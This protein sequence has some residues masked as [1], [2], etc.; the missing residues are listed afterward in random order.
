MAPRNISPAF[1]IVD[2]VCD[3]QKQA[4]YIFIRINCSFKNKK[5]QEEKNKGKRNMLLKLAAQFGIK[6]YYTA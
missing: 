1:C 6:R 4:I 2:V 3:E 5:N